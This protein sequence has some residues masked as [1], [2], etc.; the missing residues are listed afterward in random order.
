[1]STEIT[2]ATDVDLDWAL[3]EL[4]KQHRTFP[5]RALRTVQAHREAAVP[6]LIEAIEQGAA[7]LAAGEKSDNDLTFY[8]LVL[9]T[10]FQAREAW[11]A[12]RIGLSLPGDGP[13]ELFGDLIT[14]AL[15]RILAFFCADQ[16]DSI[17]EL[18]KNRTLN[19]Y[20]RWS[21]AG[22]YLRL[23]RDGR[24]SREDA[25]ARLR[26]ALQSAIANRDSEG[27][28]G[29][30]CELYDYAPIE[31]IED[32]QRAY[33]QWLVDSGVIAVQELDQSCR[34]GQSHFEA[35]LS[36]CQLPGIEDTV[37]EFRH[38]Y[39]PGEKTVSKPAAASK[40]LQAGQLT[41][42]SA[43]TAQRPAIN[44]LNVDQQQTTAM[45]PATVRNDRPRVGR[46][47]PCPCGS[48]Q[49]FKKCCGCH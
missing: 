43:A 8:G 30:V 20:V 13:F 4:S 1:M 47:D 28:T 35:E 14:G 32:I 19:E 21:A 23:V 42:G 26:H 11:P 12:I 40:T 22:S 36:R 37:E 3:T 49:K 9:L 44:W 5:E 2:E 15:P 18:L 16:V 31:A 48:G 27:A 6:R 17:D 34:D 41:D 10:E 33:D 46:N 29:I 45:A 7:S 24:I 38:W 25:V 39:W